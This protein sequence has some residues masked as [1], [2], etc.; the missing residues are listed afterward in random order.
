MKISNQEAQALLKFVAKTTDREIACQ[1]CED[2]L[3]EFV[4]A[5]ITGKSIPEA[6]KAIEE[7]LALC[8]ECKEETNLLLAALQDQ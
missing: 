2:H 1:T 4:E 7:H 8:P 3:A 6:L 5:K